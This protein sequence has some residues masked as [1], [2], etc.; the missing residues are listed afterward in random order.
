MTFGQV[1]A[2]AYLFVACLIIAEEASERLQAKA[3]F[4]NF[5]TFIIFVV[6]LML[7]SAQM[8]VLRNTKKAVP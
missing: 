5:T 4:S 2:D 8:H 3:G 6:L 7:G 1:F